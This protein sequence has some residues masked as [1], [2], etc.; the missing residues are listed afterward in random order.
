MHFGIL[1]ILIE[2]KYVKLGDAGLTG[3]EA[4]KMSV[5]ELHGHPRM[6]SKMEDAKEQLGRYG[7][8][9][10]AKVLFDE[11]SVGEAVWNKKRGARSLR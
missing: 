2:F 4:R 6:V 7:D 1:N 3:D 11:E 10:G 8:A 9:G 5:E